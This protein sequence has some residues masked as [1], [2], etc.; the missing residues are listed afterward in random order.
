MVK[1]IVSFEGQQH[2]VD[3][4]IAAD[5]QLLRDLFAPFYPDMANSVIERKP[6]EIIKIIKRAGPKGATPLEALIASPE[7]VNPAVIMCRKVQHM[8][9]MGELDYKSMNALSN[10]IEEAIKQ[11]T[12]YSNVIR[13]TLRLLQTILPSSGAI[14]EG[15]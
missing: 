4:N 11:G 13:K 12:E 10:E 14:P 9:L 2:P 3:E 8:E 7:E 6:G 1:V 15:F 5:D